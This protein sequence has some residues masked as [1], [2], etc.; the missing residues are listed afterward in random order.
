MAG[1][2]FSDASILV[3]DDKEAN[4]DVLV[5]LLEFQGYTNI[6]S[7]TDP[8][9]VVSLFHSVKPDLILLD[10]MM[11]Y[12]SGY[13][14]LEQLKTLI[15]RDEYLPILV[16]TA[17]I[18]VEAKQRALSG[19]ARDFLAKPFDLIEVALRI[20]NLLFARFLHL[21]L[22]HQ[23]QRLEQKVKERT[24]ELEQSNSDL[25]VAKERA[26]SGDRL[27]TAFIGNISHEIRTPL[28]GILG[29][30]RILIDPEITHDEKE[31]YYSYLQLSSD[32]L[33]NT[34][35]D[36]LDIS[37]I[38]SGNLVKHAAVFSPFN[39]L[40][41]IYNKF[42][43]DCQTRQL[44]LL[45]QTPPDAAEFKIYSDYELMRKVFSHLVDNAIKFTEQGSVSFG[46]EVKEN[47][48]EFFIRDTGVGIEQDAL[49]SVFEN[50]TQENL[51]NTRGYEGSGLGLS[52]IRGFL[53]LLGAEIRVESVKGQGSAFFFSLPV[54]KDDS[55]KE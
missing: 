52:I 15:P 20:E 40:K 19:G 18:A 46:F 48:F 10:L 49:E 33:I 38:V 55:G 25:I 2:T 27:K 6:H 47:K 17:D 36:Y 28:N 11:P 50:F 23:N 14:V 54:E 29:M 12:L 30:Y 5:G 21:Q 43:H 32:R 42:H 8:R 39:L 22:Q 35:S 4:I 26:E 41:E 31:E 51:S 24:R 1:L 34:V 44:D 37:L 3:V 45:L 53:K 16:L 13:E 7:T 9:R